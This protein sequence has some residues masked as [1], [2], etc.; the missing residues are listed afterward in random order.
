MDLLQRRADIRRAERE[1]AAAT[2]RIGVSRADL[3]PRFSLTGSFGIQSRNVG[4]LADEGSSFWR[5]G[6]V[7]RWNILNLKRVLSA[8]ALS[9]AVREEA[10]VRYE[11]TVLGAL[12]EVENALVQITR[13]KKRSRALEEA[14]LANS[15][16]AELAQVRYTAGL[17]N[18]LS[19]LDALDALHL[20]KD[21][22]AVS[23][24]NEALGLVS[25]YKAL[26]E[27]GRKGIR[28]FPDHENI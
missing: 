5:I 13:E 22:W 3:F 24:Q 18:Y 12:E 7:I 23:R 9:E 15:R 28:E 19:V 20:S 11:K 21:Q 10:L 1:L 16:A 17:E 8:V 25:L 2:A 27:A 26:G 6:P 4:D 14:V